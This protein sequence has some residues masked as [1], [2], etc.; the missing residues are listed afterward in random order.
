M[1]YHTLPLLLC[2]LAASFAPGAGAAGAPPSCEPIQGYEP[3][4]GL[5]RPEDLALYGGRYLLIS[6][7][8]DMM[9]GTPGSL[10]VMDTPSGVARELYPL[11]QGPST[12]AGPWGDPACPGEPGTLLSP[13]G[14]DLSQRKDGGWQLLV[15]NH[16]GREAV[17]FY[18]VI[19]ISGNNDEVQGLAWRGCV[20]APEG[21]FLNDVA[22]LP[23]GGFLV[24]HMLEK[25]NSFIGQWLAMMG[26]GGPGHVW[27]WRPKESFKQVKGSEGGLPNG[28]SLAPDGKA[29]FLNLSMD[30]RVRKVRLA[31]GKVLGE[32][33]VRGPDNSTWTP[34][35]Q[36]L[37]AS[38]NMSLFSMLPC[39]FNGEKTCLSAFEIVS[40]NPISLEKKVVLSHEGAPMGAATSALAVGDKL[41]LGS[42]AGD[43]ILRVPYPADPHP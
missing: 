36:L 38:L 37:V 17:E 1:L 20:E 27:S 43:R 15:V 11:G 10:A 5:H 4:C 13:H 23:D 32:V 18:E 33:E 39:F 12:Q 14:L 34:Q 22:A 24:T 35:G 41:Y 6:Q 30:N 3:I 9:K 19:Q 40:I 8:G 42:F 25:S 21:A 28:I 16:G 29:F 26:F 7:M 2:I 31:D